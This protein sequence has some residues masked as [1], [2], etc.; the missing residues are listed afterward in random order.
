M[1]DAGLAASV[2]LDARQLR[3]LELIRSGQAQVRATQE[4]IVP[5]SAPREVPLTPDQARVWFFTQTFPESAEYNQPL[6]LRYAGCPDPEVLSSAFAE[7]VARHD[8][9]RLRFFERDGEPMQ[10]MEPHAIVP[11]RWF[12]LGD[13]TARLALMRSVEIANVILQ[14]PFDPV[15]PPLIRAAAIRLQGG[16]GL[17]VLA[18]H[19]L[20]ADGRSIEILTRELVDLLAGRSLAATPEVRFIDYAAWR[21]RQPSQ[22]H[23]SARTYWRNRLSGDL[24]ILDIPSDRPRPDTS[25][26][27]G[28]T[29]P[30]HIPAAT[31]ERLSSVAREAGGTVFIALLAVYKRLLMRLSG[32]TDV[33]VG[34]PL[35]GRELSEIENTVGMFVNTVP[36]RT[37]LSGE[38]SFRRLLTRVRDTVIA[39]Q[40]HRDMPFEQI[41]A[42]LKGPR[43]LSLSPLFQTMFGFGGLPSLEEPDPVVND[44]LL[45]TGAAK[46]DLTLFLDENRSGIDGQIEYAADLFDEATARRM[47]GMFERLCER[48]SIE[49][50]RPIGRAALLSDAERPGVPPRAAPQF[51]LNDACEGCGL[52]FAYRPSLQIHHRRRVDRR[53]PANASLFRNRLNVL[54]IMV[55]ARGFEPLT[56]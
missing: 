14:E 11:L 38:I 43:D 6:T 12:D 16:E 55:P 41:V 30:I 26:R 52:P 49:P 7:L 53:A 18:I 20:I 56:P 5:D 13:L 28:H 39:A 17:V 44:V 3:K 10:V 31:V 32:Q 45:D 22:R 9:L 46:W 25:S 47:A 42:D 21:E 48:L 19:H 40:D 54:Y 50:D 24:P 4:G 35:L 2:P 51:A 8:T 29:V 23:D 37:D 34:T 33:I 36:L 27:R 1:T 15:Q